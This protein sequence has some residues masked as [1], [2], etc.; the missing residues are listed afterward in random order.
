M[1]PEK[2][3]R[4]FADVFGRAEV[5]FELRSP[6]FFASRLCCGA[7]AGGVCVAGGCGA[8]PCPPDARRG[9]VK[10]YH[11]VPA[12]YAETVREAA[13]RNARWCRANGCQPRWCGPCSG[14]GARTAPGS[15]TCRSAPLAS[16]SWASW[17]SRLGGGREFG[18]RKHKQGAYLAVKG[19][20]LLHVR[21]GGATFAARL[22]WSPES[23]AR[24]LL[25]ALRYEARRWGLRLEVLP[26][27]RPQR[28]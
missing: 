20:Y 9:P 3:A 10:E 13:T 25:G 21:D 1:K 8:S 28:G 24:P 16:G 22:R 2:F 15:G 5:L 12:K 7:T 18:G 4:R 27:P 19:T 6:H 14:A 11:N 23:A 17:F 26:R